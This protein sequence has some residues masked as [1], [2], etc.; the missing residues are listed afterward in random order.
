MGAEGDNSF[1]ED[2]PNAML[3]FLEPGD[4]APQEVVIEGELGPR[5]ASALEGMTVRAHVTVQGVVGPG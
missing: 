5:Y 4:Q 3:V 1:E 2:S